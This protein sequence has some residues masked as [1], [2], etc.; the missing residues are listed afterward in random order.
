MESGS[1]WRTWLSLCVDSAYLAC[2]LSAMASE[3]NSYNWMRS[4]GS[5]RVRLLTV[6]LAPPEKPAYPSDCRRSIR[7]GSSPVFSANSCPPLYR[8]IRANRRARISSATAFFVGTVRSEEHTSELQSR[9]YLV[10][11]LLL[12]KK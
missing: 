8:R 6:G 7:A 4:L 12:E 3:N 11:R 10:C 2:W 1:V 9:Q 5:G